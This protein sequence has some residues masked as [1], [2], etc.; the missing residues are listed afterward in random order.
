MQTDGKY[1]GQEETWIEGRIMYDK[2][3][4]HYEIKKTI[5]AKVTKKM[6]SNQE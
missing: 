1:V 3:Y 2:K 4:L 5:M 6:I